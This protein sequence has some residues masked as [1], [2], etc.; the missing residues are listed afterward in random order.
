MN[1]D[2]EKIADTFYNQGISSFISCDFDNAL[3]LLEKSL[4]NNPNLDKA[5]NA[6]GVCL[7][8]LGKNYEALLCFQNALKL[9]PDNE[10][11]QNNYKKAYIKLESLKKSLKC[12]LDS[13]KK[14]KKDSEYFIT[15]NNPFKIL[16]QRNPSENFSLYNFKIWITSEKIAIISLF[17]FVVGLIFHENPFFYFLFIISFYFGLLLFYLNSVNLYIT[18]QKSLALGLLLF[19]LILSELFTQYSSFK[20]NPMF[21]FGKIFGSIVIIWI[22]IVMGKYIKIL[23]FRFIIKRE[24]KK[25]FQSTPFALIF[26]FILLLAL[27]IGVQ[28]LH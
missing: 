17:V 15:T 7:S 4:E 6:R 11:Y 9:L 26:G 2:Q 27:I 24:M 14:S 13:E 5:W 21:F 1:N 20:E 12:T 25:G 16:N 28:M 18:D 3:S 19:P 23:I 22:L 10:I 8:K